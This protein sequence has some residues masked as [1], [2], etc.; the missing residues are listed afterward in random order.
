LAYAKVQTYEEYS[1]GW[2]SEFGDLDSSEL[3]EKAKSEFMIG[4]K[5]LQNLQET[6]P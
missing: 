6:A 2:A 4:K 5:F 3:L 1:S